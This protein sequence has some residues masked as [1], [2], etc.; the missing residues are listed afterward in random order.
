M[1]AISPLGWWVKGGHRGPGERMGAQLR[2]ACSPS[3]AGSVKKTAATPRKAPGAHS[4]V[5]RLNTPTVL[6]RRGTAWG[7]RWDPCTRAPQGQPGGPARGGGCCQRRPQGPAGALSGWEDAVGRGLRARRALAGTVKT[8][9]CPTRT[10][11]APATTRAPHTWSPCP[12][13]WRRSWPGAPSA[14][15]WCA[16]GF[17]PQGR[18]YS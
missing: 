9:P 13:A 10:A 1:P 17:F 15:S 7:G 2:H 6:A 16:S 14:S 3:D 8:W 5:L 11:P 18:C 12:S 4:T